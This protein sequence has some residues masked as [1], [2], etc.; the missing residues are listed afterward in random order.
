MFFKDVSVL[1]FLSLVTQ[2]A[3]P[4]AQFFLEPLY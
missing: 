1:D 2:R 4:Q 3:E